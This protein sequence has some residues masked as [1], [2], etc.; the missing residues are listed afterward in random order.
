MG[1]LKVHEVHKET[2]SED[3][4]FDLCVKIFGKCH[5]KVF[6]ISEELFCKARPVLGD[7]PYL[8]AVKGQQLE[9]DIIAAFYDADRSFQL[10]HCVAHLILDGK[11]WIA[12]AHILFHSSHQCSWWTEHIHLLKAA[13]V[14]K[15][16]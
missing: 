15:A 6:S 9:V 13:T 12:A 5:S 3:G 4:G 2:G 16:A 14:G 8:V 7:S 10:Q 11:C 1:L